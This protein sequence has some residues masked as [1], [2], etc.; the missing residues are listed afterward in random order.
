MITTAPPKPNFL[1]SY[2]SDWIA[3]RYEELAGDR[4]ERADRIRA[5]ADEVGVELEPLRIAML[6]RA[7][8]LELSGTALKVMA[9]GKRSKV[10]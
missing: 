6:R 9:E 7:C 10:A 8:E 2:D 1:E 3:G 5:R 4:L